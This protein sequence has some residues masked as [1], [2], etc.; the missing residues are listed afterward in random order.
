M[1]PRQKIAEMLGDIALFAAMAISVGL[2][3]YGTFLLAE[4]VLAVL[5]AVP[6]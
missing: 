2:C 4:S 1:T 6:Q 5:G 3:V